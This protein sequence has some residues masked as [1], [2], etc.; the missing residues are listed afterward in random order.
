MNKQ[1]IFEV[2]Y[3]KTTVAALWDGLTN[4]DV[5]QQYWYETRIESDWQVG[6]KVLY[7]RNGAITDEHLV[8]AVDRPHTLCH[9]FKPSFGEFKDEP[10]SRVTFSLSQSGEVSRLTVIHE[11]FPSQSK[12]F[13]AC[14]DGWPSI[15]SNLKTLLETGSPLPAFEFEPQAARFQ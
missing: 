1:R 3:I 6:S 13:Q 14:S 4:P 2:V 7:I 15:L 8:L 11:D 5:T 12:V 9:T 10:P